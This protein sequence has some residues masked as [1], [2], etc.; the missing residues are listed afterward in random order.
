[1]KSGDAAALDDFWREVKQRGTPLVEPIPGD[2]KH[3][4]VTFRWRGARETKNVVLFSAL[5]GVGDAP[6]KN[7]LANLPGTNVWFKTYKLRKDS[8]FT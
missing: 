8:R 5:P 4:L 1:M 3:V 6:E 2:D 7:L